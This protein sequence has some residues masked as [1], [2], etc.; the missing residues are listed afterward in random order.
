MLIH[1]TYCFAP[2]RHAYRNDYCLSCDA[3]RVA[4]QVKT[5]DFIH[6]YFIPLVP[7]GRRKHWKCSVCGNNPHERVKSTQ[8]FK[9]LTAF[10]FGLFAAFGWALAIL[11]MAR[12]G[13]APADLF[14]FIAVMTLCF[15][16]ALLWCR[17]KP[18]TNLKHQLPHVPPLP[19]DICI[20]CGGGL[21]IMGFCGQ[22][23]V[24][25]LE[26]RQTAQPGIVKW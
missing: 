25:R 17:A 24:Q 18:T 12:G 13:G 1:G 21:D 5:L 16:A 7:L 20:Y 14:G 8:G 22:C 26:L 10:A 15:I 3:V 2:R 4:E 11:M 23:R 9:V 19:A 6:V